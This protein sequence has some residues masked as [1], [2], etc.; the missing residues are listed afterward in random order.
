MWI[1]EPLELP[2]DVHTILVKTDPGVQWQINHVETPPRNEQPDP[3]PIELG[4]PQER[5]LSLQD[6][7][8]RFIREEVTR[9]ADPESTFEEEDDFDIEEENFESQYTVLDMHEENI[10]HD[11]NMDPPGTPAQDGLDQADETLKHAPAEPETEP[12]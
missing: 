1:R 12:Q 11:N 4:I 8:K 9:Q 10:E 7:M 2:L 5:P 6:E 3:N